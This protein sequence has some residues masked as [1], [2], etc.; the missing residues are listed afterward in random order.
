M[1]TCSQDESDAPGLVTH[2]R[3]H[4]SFYTRNQNDELGVM[5]VTEEEQIAYDFL[6]EIERHVV[7]S[8]LRGMLL[9]CTGRTSNKA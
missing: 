2:L 4:L 9:V 7:I 3:K 6:V 1:L 5:T 8:M